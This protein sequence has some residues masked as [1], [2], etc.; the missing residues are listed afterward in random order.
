M[1]LRTIALMAKRRHVIKKEEALGT[2]D[3]GVWE[4]TEVPTETQFPDKCSLPRQ[5]GSMTFRK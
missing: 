1:G 3:Q 5:H 4:A 2:W